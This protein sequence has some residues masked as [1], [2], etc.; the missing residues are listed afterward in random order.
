MI[1]AKI[2]YQQTSFLLDVNG[3]ANYANYGSDI[4]CS[5]VTTAVFTTIGLIEKLL[6]KEQYQL[7][8]NEA[9]IHLEVN[10]KNEMIDLIFQNL[11]DV[12]ENIERQYPK[13]LKLEIAK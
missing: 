4:V 11:K 2:I 1:K 8:Q 6:K 3:H 13:N 5:A 10:V 12:L 9:S 7:I